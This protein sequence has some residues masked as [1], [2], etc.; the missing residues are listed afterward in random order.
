MTQ[1]SM[2]EAN[3]LDKFV[4]KSREEIKVTS[5]NKVSLE[6]AIPAHILSVNT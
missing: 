4:E 5:L 3:S 6:A 1:G 2:I